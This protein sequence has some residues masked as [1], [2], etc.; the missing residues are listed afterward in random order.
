MKY[1]VVIPT[2]NAE[3]H[4]Q[5]SIGSIR[6]GAKDCEIIVSDGG[7]SDKT[8]DIALGLGALVVTAT[9]GRGAQLREGFKQSRGTLV[10]FLHADT[11]IS[12]EAFDVLDRYFENQAIKVGKFSLKFDKDDWRLSFYAQ[13]A[14][15]DSFWTSFG[16][17]G[18]V[19]RRSFFEE[20]GGFP[21]W[22]LLED[23]HFFQKARRKTKVHT[24]PAHAI[25]SAARFVRNGPIKQQVFN[26]I[27]LM[28]YLL[29]S[30]VSQLSMQYEKDR[31]K[32]LSG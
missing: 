6:C 4:I 17:Q 11:V 24:F 23:V 8:K 20:I 32:E 10:L 12:R 29:G 3:G 7:S 13:M 19:V 5:K 27:I 22:P 21:D 25:T 31:V 9:K 14:R 1:S 30:P 16:D 2:L 15:W 26:G 28:K 18:I